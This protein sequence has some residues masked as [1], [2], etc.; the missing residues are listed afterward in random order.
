MF[1]NMPLVRILTGLS[2]NE[3]PLSVRERG[4]TRIRRV[5]GVELFIERTTRYTWPL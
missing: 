5:Y 1:G 3:C 2:A 4:K